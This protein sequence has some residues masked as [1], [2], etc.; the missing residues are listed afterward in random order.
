MF[1]ID[2]SKYVKQILIVFMLNLFK[3][4]PS[5][6]TLFFKRQKIFYLN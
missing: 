2:D 3:K 1:V 4:K 5:I 6:L